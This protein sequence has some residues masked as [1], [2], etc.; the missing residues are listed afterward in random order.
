MAMMARQREISI[1]RLVGAT[2]DFIRR[3][4]LI[5][6][7]V[8]GVLGGS[9]ALLFTWLSAQLISRYFI[10]TE[11]FDSRLALLGI[12]GGAVIGVLGSATS[13][14]RQLRRLQ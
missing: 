11:F 6:G 13:V 7:F 3:P 5:E 8:K 4:F 9:L 12:L 1:M 2:D 14:R 10:Q